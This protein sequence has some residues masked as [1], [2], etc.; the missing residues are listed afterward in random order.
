MR[1]LVCGFG[2]CAFAKLLYMSS[3]FMVYGLR[4]RVSVLGCLVSVLLWYVVSFF[5]FKNVKIFSN[6]RHHL[7]HAALIVAFF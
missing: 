4:F 7:A 1:V 6:G 3:W 2:L 5:D